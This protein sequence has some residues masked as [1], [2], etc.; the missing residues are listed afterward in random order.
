[1]KYLHRVIGVLAAF[2]LACVLP[3]AAATAAG[4]NDP[5][6]MKAITAIETALATQTDINRFI[7]DYA[8]NAVVADT[9]LPG[10][11]HGRTQIYNDFVPQLQALIPATLHATMPEL[12]ILS[13]GRIACAALEVHFSF[14]LK[15]GKPMAAS[16]RQLD[17]YRKIAGKWQIFEQQI[18]YPEDTKSGM[19]VMDGSLPAEGPMVWGAAPLPGPAVSPAVAKAQIRQWLDTTAVATTITQVVSAYGPGDSELVY[20]ESTPGEL[21]GLQQIGAHY[22][23][24]ISAVSSAA[25][26]FPLFTDESDGLLG[27][28]LD[29]Q[30]LV[31]TM[32]N[33]A[34]LAISFRQSDCLRRVGDKWYSFFEMVS[35][36]MDPKTGKSVM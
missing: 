22:A 14:R 23:P 17:G 28:Q 11:Y 15:N 20:D 16:L 8:P 32:K 26:T 6:D 19:A 3:A 36:P 10:I 2:C 30:N 18:S 9:F 24:V 31:L 1:M 29:T 27:M 7:G 34:K 33:G 35:Y 5:A 13:D 12:N 25:V 4:Y 21:R